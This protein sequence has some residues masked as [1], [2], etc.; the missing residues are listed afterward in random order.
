MAADRIRPTPPRTAPSDQ[1]VLEVARSALAAAAS[2][3]RVRWVHVPVPMTNGVPPYAVALAERA[4]ARGRVAVYA[5]AGISMAQP[6]GLPNGTTLAQTIYSK[7][8][9]AFPSL[10][11]IDQ[12]NLVAVADAVAALPG[13]GD[14]LRQTAAHATEF[15]TAKPSY[16]HRVIAYLALEGVID[17]LTT[18]WDT[19]IERGG[20]SERLDAVVDQRSLSNGTQLSVLKVHGCAT[21]PASL[22]ITT[23]DLQNPPTWAREQTHAR[24]GSAVVI[25]L[26]IGD[27]AGY[28]R[29]RIEEAIADVGDVS[30]IRVVSPS[31][32]DRWT[33]SQWASVAPTLAN[34]HRIPETSDKFLELFG[35][36]YI[37]VALN[38]HVA[39]LAD[40]PHVAGDIRVAVD[41]LLATDPLSLL[42]WARQSAVLASP[43]ES[44]LR[45]SE[46]A[47]A[48]AALGRLAGA[49]I[50]FDQ[51]QALGTGDGPV[52]V[53]I[54]TGTVTSRRL[55]QEA[56]NR[57]QE[58]AARGAQHPRFLVAGGIG[59]G[60][61]DAGLPSDVMNDLDPADIIDGPQAL[62]P[63]IL[64]ADEVLAS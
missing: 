3:N 61:R 29:Q 51:Q 36:A 44:V 20:E 8:V 49:T 7:L 35:A 60:T 15:R 28:V 27:V 39:A 33:D 12:S 5:G 47:R 40:D 11:G 56:A 2:T 25:F 9:T 58:Y 42:R 34:E 10:N 19:C 45:A 30:N 6:T 57:L 38:S 21:Q 50:V 62:V 22:L 26:G 48:L 63:E 13:G 53:L 17:V 37:H 4:M 23:D 52:E 46:A 31:I 24:L 64:L 59:W 14:A 43:G 32:V 16:G 55:E 1:P 41:A 18:N 54:A